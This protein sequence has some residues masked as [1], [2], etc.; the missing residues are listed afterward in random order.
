MVATLKNTYLQSATP[1]KELLRTRFEHIFYVKNARYS[2]LEGEHG[3]FK[4]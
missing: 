3:H 4:H 1:F 2:L